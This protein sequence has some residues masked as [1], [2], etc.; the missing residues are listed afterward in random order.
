MKRFIAAALLT[1]TACGGPP[2]APA[3]A[4]PKMPDLATVDACALLGQPDFAKPFQV[5]PEKLS[6]LLSCR[7]TIEGQTVWMS[8]ENESLDQAKPRVLEGSEL[9]V[10]GRK[11]WWGVRFDRVN[12]PQTSTGTVVTELD[13]NRVLV[14]H[15]QR[16][17]PNYDIGMVARS[18][19]ELVLQR[20]VAR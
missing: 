20:L 2:P 10:D 9:T 11:A 3:P 13:A 6:S 4:T 12:E 5:P 19:S 8:V 16:T 15:A 1:L 7:W 18:R 17:P 14:M